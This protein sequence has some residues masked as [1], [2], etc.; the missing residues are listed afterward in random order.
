MSCPTLLDRRVSASGRRVAGLTDSRSY[1][2]NA[3]RRGTSLPGLTV[4]PI[5]LGG[6]RI[7]RLASLLLAGASSEFRHLRLAGELYA[8]VLVRRGRIGEAVVAHATTNAWLAIEVLAFTNGVSGDFCGPDNQAKPED[9][10]GDLVRVRRHRGLSARPME[11]AFPPPRTPSSARALRRIPLLWI[12]GV[13]F[14]ATVC[15]ASSPLRSANRPR[16][17][18]RSVATPHLP[19]PLRMARFYYRHIGRIGGPVG[20]EVALLNMKKVGT[21]AARVGCVDQLQLAFS[22]TAVL[23]RR[24]YQGKFMFVGKIWR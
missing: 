4:P 6:L 9:D 15:T 11:D 24:Y 17:C 23:L 20:L 3:H 22:S 7:R 12:I 1:S 2:D 5:G 10:H 14:R 18:H 21:P 19:Y 13:R 16:P 8:L